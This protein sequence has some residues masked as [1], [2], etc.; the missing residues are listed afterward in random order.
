[1]PENSLSLRGRAIGMQESGTSQEDVLPLGEE[2]EKQAKV[3]L[4]QAGYSCPRTAETERAL[5]FARR[6]KDYLPW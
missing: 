6:K 4:R 3:L 5:R 2:Q 1:M